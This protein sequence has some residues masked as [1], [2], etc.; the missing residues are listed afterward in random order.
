MPKDKPKPTSTPRIARVTLNFV[1][2]PSPTTTS[3]ESP[4]RRVIVELPTTSKSSLIDLIHFAKRDHLADD[5][6]VDIDKC[7]FYTSDFATIPNY[8]SISILRDGESLIVAYNGNTDRETSSSSSTSSSDNDRKN[9]KKS[10]KDKK[11]S[12]S[13]ETDSEEDTESDSESVVVVIKRSHSRHGSKKPNSSVD[14]KSH[15]RSSSKHRDEDSDG[16]KGH[17]SSSSKKKDKGND[18]EKEHK[19]KS[20]KKKGS[21]DE[22]DDRKDKKGHSRSGSAKKN[23]KHKSKHYDSDASDAK[24]KRRGSHKKIELSSE[25]S[26]VEEKRERRHSKSRSIRNDDGGFARLSKTELLIKCSQS[27]LAHHQNRKDLM[28]NCLGN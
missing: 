11:K 7:C 24:P 21:D 10:A 16:E 2:F 12:K 27:M 8:A 22:E 20:S 1:G 26:L 14:E 28:P 13:K 3:S 18:D 9:H 6:G 4:S 25:E 15:K 5:S 23:D 17:R 19:R